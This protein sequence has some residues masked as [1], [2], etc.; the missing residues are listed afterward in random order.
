MILGM[1]TLAIRGSVAYDLFQALSKTHEYLPAKRAVAETT[2][3]AEVAARG[4][5][6]GSLLLSNL[7]GRCH[8]II[9]VVGVH[10]YYNCVYYCD[11]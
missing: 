11:T 5:Q 3:L 9:G 8:I 6:F 10:M 7:T 4:L 1:S 2:L